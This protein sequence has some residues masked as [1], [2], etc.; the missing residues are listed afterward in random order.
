MQKKIHKYMELKMMGESENSILQQDLIN[1]AKV[2]SELKS[3]NN[4]KIVVTGATGLI[5][6][7]LCKSI[8]CANRL[9][10]CNITIY[11]VVRNI[12]KAEKIFENV[13]ERKKFN[14]IK[15]DFMDNDSFEIQDNIDYLIHT[16][17][18]TTS[19]LMVEK[20]V[21]TLF[22]A[23]NGTSSILEFAK[24]N[25]VSSVVYLSSMEVYGSFSDEKYADENTYGRIDILDVRSSY[26]E[27]KRI[28]ENICVAY[29]HQ[30]N[31]P[32]KI[33]RLAQTF[34]P[35]ISKEDNRVYAQFARSVIEG[36]DIVLHTKGLSE[37][38]YVYISDAIN[39]IFKVLLNGKSGESYNIANEESHMQIRQMAELVAKKVSKGKICVVYDVQS[40][41]AYAKDTKMKMDTHKVKEL[42]WKAEVSLYDTYIRMIDYIKEMT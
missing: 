24:K 25:K 40:N 30:Y 36:K 10:N 27:G 16:A 1:N 35:G 28:C 39:A 15:Y 11:A 17:A 42:G 3:L 37:G 8:L 14:I 29:N 32:V 26:S 20:P 12:F 18:V 31:V 22:T 4:K 7:V 2:I 5:G 38:N 6:S 21:D 33:V 13:I 9:Y 34:G 19:K 23:I 41:N